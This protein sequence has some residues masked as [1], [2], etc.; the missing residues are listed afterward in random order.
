MAM[1]KADE[2]P[3]KLSPDRPVP[4]I[5]QDL[6]LV[7]GDILK[8]M[9]RQFK[10]EFNRFTGESEL[11]VPQIFLLRTLVTKGSISISELAE[12]LNLANSTVSGIVDR[13][14]R[15]GFVT[16]VRD[17]EDRRI[18]YVELTEHAAHFREQVPRFNEKFLG[19]LL[20]GVDDQTLREM[21]SSF[22]QLSDLIKRFEDKDKDD[23]N[24]DNGQ[25]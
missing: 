24:T 8:A 1:T 15:D 17:K 4:E 16:R 9:H 13:L 25:R 19:E 20:R 7:L 21:A 2:R 10:K 6:G 11:T 5:A 3:D 22:R 18:V 12:H 23:K 14:E